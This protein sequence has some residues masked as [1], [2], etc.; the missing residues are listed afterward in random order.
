MRLSQDNC[1]GFLQHGFG[2]ALLERAAVEDLQGVDLR[3]VLGEV[4]AEGLDETGGFGLR[5]GVKTLAEDFVGHVDVDGLFSFLLQHFERFAKGW[6]IKRGA[7][8]NN[9]LVLSSMEPVST[10]TVVFRP[11]ATGITDTVMG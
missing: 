1:C 3:L 7:G 5:G 6:F 4:I 11:E 9:E 2:E 10:W 8:F